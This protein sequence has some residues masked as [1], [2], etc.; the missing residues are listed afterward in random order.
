VKSEKLFF[1][2]KKFKKNQVGPVFQARAGTIT[3][4]FFFMWPNSVFYHFIACGFCRRGLIL[5][6]HQN[7]KIDEKVTILS[8]LC[9][10]SIKSVLLFRFDVMGRMGH[11]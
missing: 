7:Q 6:V 8:I 2:N 11:K 5:T 10:Y 1:E 3:N 9:H 4:F